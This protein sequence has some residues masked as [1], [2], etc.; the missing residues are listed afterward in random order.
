MKSS[1]RVPILLTAAA[2]FLQHAGAAPLSD[3]DREA[4][5]DN[6]EKIRE[7]AD[8]KVNSQINVALTAYRSAVGS[9]DT[10]IALYLNCME[11]TNFEERNKKPADFRDW[12]RKQSEQLSDA[13]TRL[14]L[15]HQLQWL[16]LTVR[17]AQDKDDAHIKLAGEARDILNSTM[18][19]L[20]KMRHQ[21]NILGQDVMS[22]VFARAYDINHLKAEGWPGSPIALGAIYE[23]II[24][25]P[26]RRTGN[27]S[28][29]RD[30]WVARIQQEGALVEAASGDG[31]RSLN[32][33][34]TS[35]ELDR[36]NDQTK[37]Q[38]QWQMEV[39]LYQSGDQSGAA[40]RMLAHLQKNLAHPAARQWGEQFK[41]L[42]KPAA[43]PP[44][45]G[46]PVPSDTAVVAP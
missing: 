19:D 36:F 29:L 44:P 4:L 17:A 1:M 30:A 38:L 33:P 43:A 35:P 46:D 14:A 37:P 31:K 12:K 21:E 7:S 26:L 20:P 18:R 11:K 22:S 24:F 5:L 16:I 27:V 40:V 39:D 32:T 10:A 34:T 13:G 45:A 8:F 41:N 25:P 2:L 23:Q 9:A 15:R 6:L 28:A 42:L 3:A